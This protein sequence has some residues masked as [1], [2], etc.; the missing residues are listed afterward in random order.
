MNTNGNSKFSI[1][2]FKNILNYLYCMDLSFIF[3]AKIKKGKNYAFVRIE[4]R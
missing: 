1:S 3:A 4:N 2:L